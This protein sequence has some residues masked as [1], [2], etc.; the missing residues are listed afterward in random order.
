M[1]GGAE[2]DSFE[3]SA[4]I[5]QPSPSTSWMSWGFSR[6]DDGVGERTTEGM[7]VWPR[8]LSLSGGAPGLS[9][10]VFGRGTPD[11]NSEDGWGWSSL[12]SA[13]GSHSTPGFTI[14][15]MVSPSWTLYSFSSLASASA[16]PFRRSRCAA[17]G[18]AWG[19]AAIW[20]LRAD[21]G[22]AGDTGMVMENGGLRDL[23]VIWTAVGAN[24]G[25]ALR[26]GIS[27]WFETRTY[28]IIPPSWALGVG[29]L[30]A[31]C[32]YVA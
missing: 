25:F 11:S 26:G 8:F 15:L 20:V 32:T 13:V 9:D 27:L 22:S 23:N 6:G 5:V 28:R 4:E 17:A 2:A 24:R 19:C 3:M 21:M 18:G 30:R 16:L 10:A 14:R 7:R 29:E 12:V 31:G 1:D